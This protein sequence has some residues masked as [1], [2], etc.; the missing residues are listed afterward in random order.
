MPP[1]AAEESEPDDKNKAKDKSPVTSKSEKPGLTLDQAV[2]ECLQADPK[3]R[4]ALE[5]I[6][7]ANADLLTSSLPP[8]PTFTP[9]GI[10][11]PL[12][13]FTPE[14]PG[15]PPQTD[16]T[17]GYAIDWFLFGKRATAMET[18]R[19]GVDV[20]AAD[21]ADQVR[22][23]I[24]NVI[25]AFF[26]VLEARALL[27][28]ARK[29]LESLKRVESITAERVKLGGVGTVELD[30][31]RLSV[32]DA[33]REARN[34]E[35]LHAA[36]LSKLRAFLGPLGRDGV[37]E[38]A[39]NLEVARPAVIMSADE[40]YKLAEQARPDIISLK[41]QIAKAEAAV[42]SERS[43]G[44][45][46]VT[47]T[48]AFSRQ[49]Q[50]SIGSPDASSWDVS[51]NVSLPIFDRNQ[52]N[53]AKARSVEVQTALNLQSQ[54]FELRAE[55]EQAADAFRIAVANVTAN[56]PEQ[57][58]AA[59]DVRDKIEA[60]FK[61]G[62]RTLLEVVDAEKAYRDTYRTFILGQSNYWHALHRLNAAIGKRVLR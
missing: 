60:G 45:P 37:L 43:K 38:L 17:F 47:P 12:R 25:A 15:G 30:R 59:Q 31:I 41:R 50:S 54:L 1:G 21:Y 46:T 27:D 49:F 22:L 39:G 32:Y 3:L 62:G 61:A 52:G 6:A 7:Q 9:D 11:L 5:N 16:F 58:K 48:F 18:A 14:N 20:S 23:R 19:L 2:L 33:Q 42:E 29:D 10:F 53:I 8:N 56:D 36:A 57:L 4:A 51:V 28:L 55:V 34:R 13:R 26:D 44:C 35:I 24:A 40:V